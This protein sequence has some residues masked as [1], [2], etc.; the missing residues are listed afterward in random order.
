LASIEDA[1][2]ATSIKQL[3]FGRLTLRSKKK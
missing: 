1:E 2:R 3:N